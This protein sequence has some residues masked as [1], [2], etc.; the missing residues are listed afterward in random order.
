[1]YQTGVKIMDAMFRILERNELKINHPCI[2]TKD[3]NIIVGKKYSLKFKTMSFKKVVIQRI[4]LNLDGIDLKV[5]FIA[6]NKSIWLRQ[7]FEEQY[8]EEYDW[9]LLDANLVEDKNIDQRG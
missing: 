4:I 1:M 8:W 6:E 2:A 3:Q 5:F 9:S 7:S